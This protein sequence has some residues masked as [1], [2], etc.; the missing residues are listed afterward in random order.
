MIFKHLEPATFVKRDNRFRVQVRVAG[1]TRAAHLPNSGR[2]EELLVPG[3]Q[4]WVIPVD[5]A[6]RP[7]RRTAYDMALVKYAGHL[8]SVDARLPGHLVAEALEKGQLAGFERY[9]DVRRE[10]NLGQSRIDF[11]LQ[12]AAEPA[13]CWIEVKSVT[14]VEDGTA[15]FPDAPTA[16]GRR[17]VQELIKA[18]K[19]GHQAAVVFVIQRGDAQRFTPHDQADPAF[20]QV[21]RQAA[22][23]GVSVH[24]W[25]CQV[26]LEAIQLSEQVPVN[27]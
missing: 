6:R 5:L 10:V 15:R 24:A 8:V 13:P 23:R 20:G 3:R 11:R 7:K 12:G 19:Q 21:L 18:V 4:V 17:H 27:L 26:S 14:L 2:L 22:Q 16:R 25:R 1:H 9:P